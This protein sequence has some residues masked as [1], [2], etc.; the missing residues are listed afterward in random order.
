MISKLI[1]VHK[2]L[3]KLFLSIK[4][5]DIYFLKTFK[6]NL[7]KYKNKDKIIKYYLSYDYEHIV[8]LYK[9]YNCLCIYEFQYLSLI[10]L[11]NYC[12]DSKLNFKSKYKKRFKYLVNKYLIQNIYIQN[13]KK[14]KIKNIKM[15]IIYIYILNQIHTSYGFYTFIQYFLII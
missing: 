13:Q 12:N 2:S 1:Y 11:K 6:R 5:F 3:N 15:A 9:T 4:T 7:N 10:I 8:N 14:H